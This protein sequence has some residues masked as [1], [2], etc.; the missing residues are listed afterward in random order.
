MFLKVF[1]INFLFVHACFEFLNEFTTGVM[2]IMKNRIPVHLSS[3]RN[4]NFFSGAVVFIEI[5]KSYMQVCRQH[6]SRESLLLI[7][8]EC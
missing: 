1:R 6:I 4:L 8:Y 5:N 2:N 7:E 3:L